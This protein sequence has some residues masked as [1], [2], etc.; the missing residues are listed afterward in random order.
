VEL[1]STVSLFNTV[2]H[3]RHTVATRLV[4]AGVDIITVQHLLGHA[5]IPMTARYSRSPGSSRIAAVR[6]LDELFVR[7]RSLIGP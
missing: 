2:R 5:K 4:Q 6:R 7:S 1:H 3:R